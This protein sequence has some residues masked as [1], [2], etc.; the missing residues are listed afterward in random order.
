MGTALVFI[1]IVGLLL[2]QA[3]VGAGKPLLDFALVPAEELGHPQE[4]IPVENIAP[5][6]LKSLGLELMSRMDTE[7]VAGIM[8]KPGDSAVRSTYQHDGQQVFLTIIRMRD[9]HEA[10]QFYNAWKKKVSRKLQLMHV[11]IAGQL[12]RSYN[13]AASRAYNAWKIE[14]WVVILEVPGAFSR[15]WPLINAARETV[16]RSFDPDK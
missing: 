10:S 1:L 5:V 11:D 3:A 2:V 14:N 7:E 12:F 9:K 6:D 8:L 15:A 13:V 4:G 16:A